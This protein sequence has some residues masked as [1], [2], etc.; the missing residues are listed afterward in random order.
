MLS[1][2]LRGAINWLRVQGGDNG[3]G[4]TL[5]IIEQGGVI[6]T[7]GTEEED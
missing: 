5:I 4:E 6:R 2:E 7:I 1:T 3:M